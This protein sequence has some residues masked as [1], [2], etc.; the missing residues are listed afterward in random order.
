[1]WLLFGII[2]R[3]GSSSCGGDGGSNKAAVAVYENTVARGRAVGR[4]RPT[5]ALLE[6]DTTAHR[7]NTR[8]LFN[9]IKLISGYIVI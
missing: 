4:R 3:S 2:S 5:R 7:E 1:M 6:G 9:R 8:Q